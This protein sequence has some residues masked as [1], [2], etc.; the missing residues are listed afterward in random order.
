MSD[1]YLYA[2]LESLPYRI[3]AISHRWTLHFHGG[4]TGSNPVGDANKSNHL[5]NQSMSTQPVG[6]ANGYRFAKFPASFIKRFRFQLP[7]ERIARVLLLVA[8][9][10]LLALVIA[11][12]TGF[13]AALTPAVQASGRSGIT[14]PSHAPND[15]KFRQSSSLFGGT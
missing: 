10:T 7:E 3:V 14:V 9:G 8:S 5:H 6:D 13:G 1:A 2:A 11:A 12:L 15:P 4:N